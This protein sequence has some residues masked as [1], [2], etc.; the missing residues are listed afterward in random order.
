MK[1]TAPTPTFNG[2]VV[3]TIFANDGGANGS[4]GVMTSSISFNLNVGAFQQ[5]SGDYRSC[6]LGRQPAGH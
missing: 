5:H 1:Y 6:H 3:M 4:G 2:T